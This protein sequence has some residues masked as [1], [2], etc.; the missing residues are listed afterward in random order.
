MNIIFLDLETTGLDYK[1]NEVIQISGIL[2]DTFSRKT[3]EELNCYIESSKPNS[4][5][6]RRINGYY[7]GKW[8]DL[9]IQKT[10]MSDH[11]DDIMKFL[12]KGNAIISHNS[13]FDRP[14]LMAA[15]NASDNDMEKY[16]PKYFM[17][18]CTLAWIFKYKGADVQK[19]SL[20]Y[21]VEKFKIEEKRDVSHDALQ[22]CKLLKEVFFK[23]IDNIQVKL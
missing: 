14:F 21:L 15:L 18:N 5:G 8:K 1:N 20:N 22:D 12:R 23:L 6:A 7:M 9:G 11:Y 2:V 17:D 13:S 4:E 19:I 10:K 16:M 3:L